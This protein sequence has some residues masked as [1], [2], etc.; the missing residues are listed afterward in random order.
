[1]SDLFQALF[2]IETMART[3]REVGDWEL[4]GFAADQMIEHD[5]AYGGSH[6]AKAL[7]LKQKGDARGAQKE[8][9][10]A[11]KGWKDADPELPERAVMATR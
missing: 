4:A 7:V 5:A 6:L 1:M 10:L 2:R 9:E 8:M 3:A 11:K